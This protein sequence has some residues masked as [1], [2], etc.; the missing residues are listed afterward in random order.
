MGEERRSSP[1]EVT[2]YDPA[3][4]QVMSSARQTLP[5]DG[6]E[7]RRDGETI[8]PVSMAPLEK[9]GEY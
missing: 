8:V 1:L 9:P 3:T 2:V 6:L 7:K 4:R 5:P